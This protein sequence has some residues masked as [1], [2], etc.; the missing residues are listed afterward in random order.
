MFS[1][2]GI[3][4]YQ[5]WN[6]EEEYSL[7]IIVMTAGCI[8]SGKTYWARQYI[9][10]HPNFVRINKDDIR[11]EMRRE[12]GKS[13]DVQVPE[14]EVIAREE[15]LILE[16]LKYGKSVILDSTH[17]NPVH[18]RERVPNLL[19]DSFP[20][21]KVL[22]NATFLDVPLETCISQNNLREGVERLEEKIIR[23]MWRQW[24]SHW[25]PR[26]Y[27]KYLDRLVRY[28]ESEK[29]LPK[30]VTF[31][32]D[33]SIFQLGDRGRWEE[34]LVE[35]DIPNIPV[36]NVCKLYLASDQYKV[37]FVSGRKDSCREQTEKALSQIF[38]NS[39]KWLL[40]MRPSN[41]NEKDSLVK[42]NIYK[43]L[44]EPNYFIEC[45]YDDRI[46]VVDHIRNMGYFVFDLNQTRKEF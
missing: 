31:D 18:I 1:K 17:L 23:G 2:R 44:I 10:T 27:W 4:W 36:V 15:R 43:N 28:E 13:E 46:S 20:E 14:K 29:L 37:I 35:K 16:A 30:A 19:R 25:S 32:L 11:A 3:P 7:P 33:G 21:V 12:S 9:K 22:V 39:S 34:H 38:G 45:C 41:S 42:E 24:E 5:D 26:E 6:P 40:Y 8:G